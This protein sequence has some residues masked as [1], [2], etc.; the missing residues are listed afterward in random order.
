[1]SESATSGT[2]MISHLLELV[3]VPAYVTDRCNR[4]RAVNRVFAGLVGDP[5]G[6]GIHGD[7]LFVHSL[8]LGPYR[9]H[10]P[11]R[12]LEVPS[13][14]PLLVAEME[15]GS[16]APEVGRLLG[17]ALRQDEAVSRLARNAVQGNGSPDWDGTVHFRGGDGSMEELT[18][19]VIPL[20]G[21]GDGGPNCFLN[22]WSKASRRAPTP[23]RAAMLLSLTPREREVAAMYARGQNAM[24]IASALGISI[25]TAHDH[26]DSIYSKLGIHSRAELGRLMTPSPR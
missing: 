15:S 2:A 11:R 18:E 12:Q 20:A 13:C 24:E 14:V 1:M 17:N 23:E 19:T 25:H 21:D 4:V 3:A 22:L 26:R 16:L 5:V 10:F 6:Q 7:D 8:I 9:D